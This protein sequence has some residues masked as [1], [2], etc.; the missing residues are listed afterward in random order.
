MKD[1]HYHASTELTRSAIV[2]CLQA[3]QHNNLPS[4]RQRKNITN[5]NKLRWE[6]KDHKNVNLTLIRF[7][8]SFILLYLVIFACL[9]FASSSRL[10]RL[11]EEVVSD[12]DGGFTSYKQGTMYRLRSSVHVIKWN[13][14]IIFWLIFYS[15]LNRTNPKPH[16]YRFENESI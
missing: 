1:C 9:S 6:S 16:V 15:S 5:T 8:C 13:K 12:D 14:S 3:D 7:S 11:K 2:P 4:E 10:L